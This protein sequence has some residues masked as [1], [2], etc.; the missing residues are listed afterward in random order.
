MFIIIYNIIFDDALTMTLDPIF[1][2]QCV[3]KISNC[4]KTWKIKFLIYNN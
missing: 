3:T 1:M 4:A 2:M